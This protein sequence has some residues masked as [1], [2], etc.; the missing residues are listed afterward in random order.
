ME[1]LDS[2][3]SQRLLSDSQ[4]FDKLKRTLEL[5]DLVKFAKTFPSK[6]TMETDFSQI[7]DFVKK[8]AKDIEF[9]NLR[10]DV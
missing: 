4:S 6:N 3:K 5:A 1:I 2:F 10:K 9:E 8:S 7:R